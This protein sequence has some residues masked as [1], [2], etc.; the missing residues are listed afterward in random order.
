[1]P[2]KNQL[3]SMASKRKEQPVKA[4]PAP[5]P[6][7]PASKPAPAPAIPAAK[8]T[9]TL[10]QTE[11]QQVVEATLSK[12]LLKKLIAGVKLSTDE[13]RQVA[14]VCRQVGFL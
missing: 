5:A 6:S 1:M 4:A 9:L 14:L 2:I 13:Q 11:I 7:K 8:P 3:M 12:P 10:N